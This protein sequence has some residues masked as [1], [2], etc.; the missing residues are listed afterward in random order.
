MPESTSADAPLE[1]QEFEFPEITDFCADWDK[2]RSH[3][4][5][6]RRAYVVSE[7]N[8]LVTEGKPLLVNVINPNVGS[9]I[10]DLARSHICHADFRKFTKATGVLLHL[11][12]GAQPPPRDE[13]GALLP[14]EKRGKVLAVKLHNMAS[15]DPDAG[16][17]ANAGMYGGREEQKRFNLAKM[18]YNSRV[19]PYEIVEVTREP[20][21]FEFADAILI[22]QK[23]GWFVTVPQFQAL[24]RGENAGQFNRWMI[25]EKP[26][27]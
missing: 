25:V 5:A 27:R 26:L 6:Q 3:P 17:H 9:D 11:V 16:P 2:H 20:E 1:E 14:L 10:Q 19:K 18:N 4:P 8:R 23:Y 22:L 21:L 7:V 24:G 15:K 13:C 12:P